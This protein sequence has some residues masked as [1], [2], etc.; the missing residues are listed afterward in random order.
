MKRLP[1]ISKSAF[2]DVDLEYDSVKEFEKYRPF[3][4]GKV[5][6]F[7]TYSDILEIIIYYGKA[8]VKKEVVKLNLKEKTI[9][10]CCA[11]FNLKKTDFVC[12]KKRQSNPLHWNY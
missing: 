6:D 7:G 8:T 1:K 4:I 10:F 11:V 9:S 3:I 12:Y 2:W 5:F